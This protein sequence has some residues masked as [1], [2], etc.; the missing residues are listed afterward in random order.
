MDDDEATLH[1][2]KLQI[3]AMQKELVAHENVIGEARMLC[4]K[5]LNVPMLSI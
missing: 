5:Y 2:K 4:D 3:E 1:D